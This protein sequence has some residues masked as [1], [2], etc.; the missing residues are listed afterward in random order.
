MKKGQR[1]VHFLY[2]CLFLALPGWSTTTVYLDDSGHFLK[3]KPAGMKSVLTGKSPW[4]KKPFPFLKMKNEGDMGLSVDL[5]DLPVAKTPSGSKSPK[6]V[7]KSG[8]LI[9]IINNDGP[10]E[11][12]NDP[13]PATPIGGNSGVTIGEQRLI[14]FQYAADIWAALLN[15]D[16]AV[17]I[18]AEFNAKTCNASSAILGSAGPASVRASFSGAPIS[19]TWYP[20]ALANQ[21]YGADMSPSAAEINA[22]FN[23]SID[24]NDGCLAG[25]DWYYGIDGSPTPGDIDLVSVLLHEFC[26]GLGFLTVA[27]AETGQKLSGRNDVFLN[28]LRDESVGKNWNDPSMSDTD[29]AASAIDTGDLTW[30]GTGANALAGGLSNGVHASGNIE[31]Y[32][33]NPY[34]SGSSVSH[35]STSLY[36]NALME[37]SYTSVNHNPTLSAALLY[38]LGWSESSSATATPTP[39]DTVVPP[40]ATFTPTNTPT[41]TFTQTSTHTF[42]PTNTPTS[43]LVPPTN[44]PTHTPT[45]T[46][47]HTPTATWTSTYTATPTDTPTNTPTDSPSPTPTWTPSP[48][49]TSTPEPTDTPTATETETFTPE[50]TET[51]TETA[52]PTETAEG[53]NS[54]NEDPTGTPLATVTETPSQTMEPTVTETVEP[55]P[56]DTLEPGMTPTPTPSEVVVTMDFDVEPKGS[57]NGIIDDQDLIVWYGEVCEGSQE[58]KILFEFAL[59]WMEN[60]K[61]SK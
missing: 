21:L 43:T 48:S 13:T 26:H 14:A 9:V 33:P 22:E 4:G 18:A 20:I 23:S 15:I 25:T 30:T 32:A 5:V 60:N 61:G 36:P 10:G 24:N 42:T 28:Q 41:S 29:R 6:G 44:T 11:G 53:T 55:S 54:P 50:P 57:P 31:M 7:S 52:S 3:E 59:H 1:I 40:T 35:Y 34:E 27:D 16:V 46:P 37:P 2:V 45:N 8:P 47:T 49:A 38:D 12:F 58:P 51:P 39:T 19:N 17:E 56:T